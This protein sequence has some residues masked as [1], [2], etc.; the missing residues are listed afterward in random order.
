MKAV[1]AAF[2]QEK[3]LVGAYSVITNLRM[4]LFEALINIYNIYY[5]LQVSLSVCPRE[6]RCIRHKVHIG[7]FIAFGLADLAWL[8]QLLC[9]VSVYIYYIYLS[10]CLRVYLSIYLL[11][12]AGPG[13]VP[14]VPM[15]PHLPDKL[16]LIDSRL[17]ST[18]VSYHLN[19]VLEKMF[20]YRPCNVNAALTYLADTFFPRH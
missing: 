8:C 16:L 1:V 17:P 2:N 13:P 4:E 19:Q 15:F 11:G 20:I 9:Q 12:L 7:L 10:T 3:A 5:Y 14:G 18:P 6:L